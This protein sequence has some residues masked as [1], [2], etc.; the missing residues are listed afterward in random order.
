MGGFYQEEWR[1]TL[2]P[3][4]APGYGGRP[5]EGVTEYTQVVAEGELDSRFMKGFATYRVIVEVIIV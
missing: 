2:T 3:N 1:P 5:G 4:G